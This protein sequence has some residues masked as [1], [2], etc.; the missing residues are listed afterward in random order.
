MIS[1][2]KILQ[3]NILVHNTDRL[4]FTTRAIDEIKKIKNKTGVIIVICF[5]NNH[6]ASIWKE[7]S[8]ELISSGLSSIA[9]YLDKNDEAGTNYL[10]KI[11][12]LINSEYRYSCSM[13]D[14]ILISSY[15][16]DYVID[17]LEILNNEK[18]L[19]IAPLISNGIPSVDLF[20]EDFC[21][22]EE[23]E[24]LHST[25][26]DTRIEN[27]WGANYEILNKERKTW[28]IDFYD[29]VKK[30]NHHY[31]GIHPVRVS[32]DAHNKLAE[33]ICKNPKRL[34]EENEYRMEILKFPY[35]CNSF[36]FIKTETWK[37][38]IEDS[39]LFRDS[40]DEVP[41]NLYMEK[42]DLHMVF[43]RNGFC[44]HMAYNTINTPD[45]THQKEVESY[46]KINLIDK[47]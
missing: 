33:Y 4:D 9:V 28:G 43:I 29:D 17:N 14:D 47:I 5:S 10:N 45:R 22:T 35:F 7:K 12:Y 30:I 38:I 27:L 15:L 18:N 6:E 2:E 19:F 42:N 13:D 21:T 39:S 23:K 8:S 26:I 41:L 44:L 46:Y 37:K 16:W 24:S 25:F 34:L 1:K 32:I 20:I 40:Y 36:Y 11:K 3:V 31:K